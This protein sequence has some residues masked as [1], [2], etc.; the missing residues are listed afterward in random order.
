MKKTHFDKF[1]RR[2]R[3]PEYKH[4]N[5]IELDN[6]ML[7][8]E[9]RKLIGKMTKEDA[10][11]HVEPG[12]SLIELNARI[13]EGI[14]YSIC[15]IEEYNKYVYLQ[16]KIKKN[17]SKKVQNKILKIRAKIDLDDLVRKLEKAKEDIQENNVNYTINLKKRH[18]LNPEIIMPFISQFCQTYN[19]NCNINKQTDIFINCLLSKKKT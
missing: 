9:N 19:I 3:L 11:K 6:I 12:K 16:N 5:F 15:I 13:I 4:D 10:K 1:N 17:S 14:E 7:L 2:P 8:D 18:G